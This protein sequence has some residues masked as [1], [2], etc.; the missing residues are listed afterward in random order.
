[1]SETD[2]I[3]KYRF[4]TDEQ[5]LEAIFS[6]LPCEIEIDPR[7]TRWVEITRF[8]SSYQITVS[9]SDPEGE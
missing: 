8:D 1:M 5:V 4:E 3:T 7:N 2:K 9:H 6:E